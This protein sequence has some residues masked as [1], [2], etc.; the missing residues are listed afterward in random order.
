MFQGCK[1]LA[2]MRNPPDDP[3][4]PAAAQGW[5]WIYMDAIDNGTL[6][7]FIARWSHMGSNSLPNRLLWRIFMCSELI[8]TPQ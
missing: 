2:Q 6:T 7:D 4:N 8:P 3:L 1:H 5:A